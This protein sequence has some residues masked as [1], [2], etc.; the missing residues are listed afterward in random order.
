MKGEYKDIEV[1]LNQL[2]MLRKVQESVIVNRVDRVEEA[3][4][5]RQQSK[6]KVVTKGSTGT[7]ELGYRVKDEARTQAQMLA[8]GTRLTAV[9]LKAKIEFQSQ[10]VAFLMARRYRHALVTSA[11]YRVIFNNQQV[12]RAVCLPTNM[13]EL[14]C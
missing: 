13:R 3:N 11:F 10:M 4:A 1:T 8:Q 2:E 5:E 9:G 12:D 7:T 14:L 6:G